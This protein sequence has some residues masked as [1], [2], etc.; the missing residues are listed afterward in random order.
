MDTMDTVS[1]TLE[2]VPQPEVFKCSEDT[3]C[4]RNE[5][6]TE[7]K[8]TIT[9][10]IT[11]D[12]TDPITTTHNENLTISD[13]KL[14]G[15]NT[16]VAHDQV[17]QNDDEHKVSV[18]TQKLEVTQQASS[19]DLK[20]IDQSPQLMHDPS[21]PQQSQVDKLQDAGQDAQTKNE[22]AL[23]ECNKEHVLCKE[24]ETQH[25]HDAY[26]LAHLRSKPVNHI[27]SI[28]IG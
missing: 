1:T 11:T 17:P 23:P 26:K 19:D 12:D 28:G 27:T 3:V 13:T 18:I 8:D 21:Q 5:V 25:E 10:Q 7:Y 15:S 6:Q 16:L 14:Q 9:H 2:D 20:N 22:T 4:A 24:H